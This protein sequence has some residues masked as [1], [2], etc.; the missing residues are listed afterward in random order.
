MAYNYEY[1]YTDSQI[2]NDDW[3]LNKM[4]ALNAKFEEWTAIVEELSALIPTVNKLDK[5]VTAL[6]SAFS[7]LAS[8]KADLKL[9]MNQA[10]R[11][12]ADIRAMLDIINGLDNR[13]AWVKK[14]VDSVAKEFDI[15]LN[16]TAS[17]LLD[18][19]YIS[20]AQLTAQ[21]KALEEY[22]KIVEEKSAANVLNTVIG[23][24]V[25]LDENNKEI[26]QYLRYFGLTESELL[27]LGL[28][29]EELEEYNL[30]QRDFAYEGKKFLKKLFI[31]SP[32]S[33]AKMPTY[34]VMSDVLTYLSNTLT[35]DEFAALNL[36]ESDIEE[37]DLTALEWLTYRGGN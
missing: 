28:T 2:F 35:A 15:K 30:T 21:I 26:Y 5:R 33:G 3:L 27:E 9:V 17:N 7:E 10:N 19:I 36:T 37:L 31:F 13:F 24:R 20:N 11:N 16:I 34:M 23:S 32:V 6:E 18:K 22:I 8:I 1:P 4:K 12:T 25:S 14:Y 29:E